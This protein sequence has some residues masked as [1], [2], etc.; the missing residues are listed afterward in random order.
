MTTKT[1]Q[2]WGW[3]GLAG[4]AL[5]AALAGLLAAC[6]PVVTGTAAP[7]PTAAAGNGGQGA[8]ELVG[9]EWVLTSLRGQAPVAGTQITLHFEADQLGGFAGC[10]AY[11]GGP[12]S[13]GYT[14]SNGELRIP[15]PAITAQGCLEPP[16]VMEQ[17]AAYVDALQQATAY[18]VA[19]DVLELQDAAGDTVLTYQRQEELSMDPEAL[20][21][22]AWQLVTLNGQA[23]A[24]GSTLTLAFLDE[25]R[26]GGHA[27]CRDYVLGYQ[28]DEERIAF[29][30]S[31]MIGPVCLGTDSQPQADLL[32]RQE[33]A[34]TDALT[35]TDRFRLAED[36]GRLELLSPRGDSLVFEHLGPEGQPPVEGP[37][38]ELLAFAEPNRLPEADM[39]TTTTTD[40]LS[41]TEVTL[42]LGE[43]TGAGTAG[44]NQYSAAYTL[45]GTTI[46]IEDAVATEMFCL[47]P[48]GAIAQEQRYLAWLA[49]AETAQV[50][51]R[52]LWLETG[53]G[54]ALLFHAPGWE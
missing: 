21:G 19:G 15:V 12:D 31:A 6:G 49:A 37:D 43:G 54:R 33:G 22:T 27:G 44:C 5:L 51:G 14:A 4:G 47:E 34:F 25:S 13:G 30:Y 11:G 38:W 2:K 42:T 18:R 39:P 24:E 8:S 20:P 7:S 41:G 45:E 32:L 28:G 46:S 23:P 29:Y 50:H 3:R 52:Q 35:W 16:G 40:V 17:E 48:E 10:N 9:T 26:A 53:D 1:W 36:G